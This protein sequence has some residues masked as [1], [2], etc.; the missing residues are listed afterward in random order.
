[1]SSELIIEKARQYI[2]KKRFDLNL[3]PSDAVNLTDED[4]KKIALE[5]FELEKHTKYSCGPTTII[6][7]DSSVLNSGLYMSE[8]L[9]KSS[10]VQNMFKEMASTYDLLFYCHPIEIKALPKDPNRVHTLEDLKDINNRALS[11]VNRLKESYP[12]RIVDLLG[13]LSLK[14][15]IDGTLHTIV[16]R[17]CEIVQKL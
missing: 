12:E 4:Q 15:R 10:S 13:T 14:D 11:L 6:V 9:Y 2:S 16:S 8:D 17:Y 5:Q 3:K 1:M 7:S